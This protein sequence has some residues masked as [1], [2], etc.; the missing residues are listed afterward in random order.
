MLKASDVVGRQITVRDGGQ[1]VG[2]IK[3][4]VVDQTGRQVIGIVVSDGVFSAARVVVW[5]AVQAFGPDTV[6]IDSAASVVK[7]EDVPDIQAVL[8]KQTRI[9]GLKLVTTT[10]KELGKIAD[11]TFDETAGD[12]AGFE[13][14]SGLFSDAFEG[15]PFLPIPPAIELGKD[16]AFVAPEVEATIVPSG[17]LKAV[18]SK[19]PDK[20]SEP[21]K[22][23]PDK[24]SEPGTGAV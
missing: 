24:P 21:D 15:T 9:K 4:L 22:P 13:L 6:I 1:I 11:F 3:D 23:G 5:K 17:G 2:K 18:F 12:V 19:H 10:G 8:D 20:P 16:V 7:A 14:S